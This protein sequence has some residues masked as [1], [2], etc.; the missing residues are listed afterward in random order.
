MKKYLALAL[1]LLVLAAVFAPSV[2]AI[3]GGRSLS[4]TFKCDPPL[5]PAGL[6]SP[7]TGDGPPPTGLGHLTG[8]LCT[9]HW[10]NFDGVGYYEY[11]EGPDGE[12]N[13]R[14]YRYSFDDDGNYSGEEEFPSGSGHIVQTFAGK[15]KK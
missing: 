14:A 13:Y 7:V 8:G 10:T 5:S 1:V 2:F 9:A 6:G 12:G 11:D 15:Y 3:S 4:G